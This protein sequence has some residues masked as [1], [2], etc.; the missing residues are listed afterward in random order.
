VF[1]GHQVVVNVGFGVAR[2]RLASLVHDGLLVIA[3]RDAYGGAVTGLSRVGPLGSGQAASKLVRVQ[4]RDL[5]I[6]EGSAVLT[7][8]WQATGPGGALFPVLD[9]DIRLVPAGDQAVMLRLDGA[10]RPPLGIA[11]SGLDRAILHRVA[12][13]TVRDFLGRI[14]EAIADPGAPAPGKG[15][16]G[17]EPRPPAIE[18]S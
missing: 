3:S 12:A 16:A 8:R 15:S 10:Y 1:V 2:A 17:E 4:A 18:T 13:A 7:L 14:A 5:M 9:A 6:A 11:G